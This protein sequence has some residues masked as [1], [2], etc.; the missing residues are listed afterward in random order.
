MV[1]SKLAL[2]HDIIPLNDVWLVSDTEKRRRFFTDSIRQATIDNQQILQMA[3]HNPDREIAYYA[4]SLQTTRME[5]LE[6]EL[7]Q[8]AGILQEEITSEKQL[9]QLDEYA[10]MLHEYLSNKSFV[11]HVTWRNKQA[12]YISLL[13]KLLALRPENNHYYIT[14]AEELMDVHHYQEAAAV[15]KAFKKRFPQCEEPYLLYIRLAQATRNPEK[16]QH[17][18]DELKALPIELSQEALRVL[19]FWDKGRRTA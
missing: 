17:R 15:C 10:S 2:D 5:K 1:E 13:R 4:V 11:D 3:M 14:L 16:L 12:D 6:N 9:K 8:K 7:F 19:R 18:I